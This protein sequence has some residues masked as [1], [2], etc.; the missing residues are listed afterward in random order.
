MQKLL[1]CL[2]AVTL[3]FACEN[4][5]KLSD[6]YGNFQ[7][8]EVIISSESMGLIQ[9][10]DIEEGE[11]LERMEIIAVIDTTTKHDLIEELKIQKELLEIKYAK[12]LADQGKIA[13]ELD[14]A[15]KDSK[16]YQILYS[17]NAIA[18]DILENYQHKQE[19]LEQDLKA[20]DISLSLIIKEIE[21]IDIKIGQ[22]SHQL[23]KSYIRS[24]ISGK[25]IAKYAQAG[26]YVS[27]GKPIC[28]IANLQA[29]YLQAYIS[30]KQLSQI[31]LNEEV[32]ILYDSI[33]GMNKLKGRISFISDKAEFT[34]KTIQTRDE[35]ANL[36]YA[37]KI[38]F[39]YNKSIKIGMPAEVVFKDR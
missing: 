32:T 7:C 25:V 2:M 13:L 1:L 26:E 39:D 27:V 35:R 29:S 37:I 30:E 22:A 11:D 3:L 33:S 21:Q 24:P 15:K 16:R 4:S 8:D 38:I 23:K 14:K 31:S 28:K 5:D 12:G 9:I 6:A 19:L 34:P 10:L 36:V 20:S 17:Q 18:K